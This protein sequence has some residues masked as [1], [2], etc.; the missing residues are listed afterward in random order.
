MDGKKKKKEWE[1]PA[2]LK[3]AFRFQFRNVKWGRGHAK[4][5]HV[6]S[7]TALN[8]HQFRINTGSKYGLNSKMKKRFSIIGFSL[9]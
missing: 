9:Q 2:N 3:L 4:D 8:V 7:F 5:G 1:N 6:V